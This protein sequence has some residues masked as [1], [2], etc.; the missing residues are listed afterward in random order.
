MMNKIRNSPRILAVAIVSAL[1]ISVL[2]ESNPYDKFRNRTHSN[3]GYLSEEDEL[4]LGEQVHQELIKQTPLVRDRSTNEYVNT[5]GQ[6]LASASGRPNI[7]WHFYVVDDN[8]I[9]IG[10]ASCRES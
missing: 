6:R 1:F 8:S 10:R 7:P 2:A 9:K 3:K 5:L 4:Q